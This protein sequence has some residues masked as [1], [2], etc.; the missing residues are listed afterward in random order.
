M[1]DDTQ[2][3]FSPSAPFVDARGEL[4]QLIAA[5]FQSALVMRS[6]KGA[7]RGNHYHHTDYHYCWLQHGGLV[8]AHRPVGETA[9][10][11]QWR[12]TPGQI[13]YSPP[14]YEH[15]MHFTADSVVVVF[16]RNA[17]E[18]AHYEEDIVRIAPLPVTLPP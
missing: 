11:R 5:P 1:S 17:R 3:I 14:L 8:Y 12:I 18:M 13:F 4:Q 6:V 10:P 2:V 9:P 15:V 7:I 16:A